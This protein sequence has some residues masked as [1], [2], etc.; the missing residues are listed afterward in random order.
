M[1]Y[2]IRNI[3]VFFTS[4][5]GLAF[6]YRSVLARKGPLV[7]VVAFHDVSDQKWFSEVIEMLVKEFNVISP[8]NFH[9]QKFQRKKINVLLSFDDGYHSWVSVA[10]PVLHKFKLKALFF[11]STG[12]LDAASDKDETRKY[13]QERLLISHKEPLSWDGLKLLSLSGHTIGG[14]SV[15]HSDLAKLPLGEA[16][17]DVRRGKIATEIQ[18]GKNLLDFAYPFGRTENYNDE[19]NMLV[20]DS[21]YRYIYSAMPGFYSVDRL[22]VPRTLLDS[23]LKPDTVR[24]WMYGAYDVFNF[25][26]HR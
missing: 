7:R 10:L 19:L 13:I 6:V 23:S 22:L 15:T 4:I 25:I 16:A 8:E 12:L 21:N 1:K 26:F 5:F 24:T 2:I 3:L 11:V 17:E 18:I 9:A 20:F 14:H